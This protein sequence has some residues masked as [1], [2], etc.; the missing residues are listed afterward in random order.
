MRVQCDKQPRLQP[1]TEFLDKHMA[2]ELHTVIERDAII[3]NIV[4][5][6]SIPMTDDHWK[7]YS[8]VL[9]RCKQPLELHELLAR[10]KN[11]FDHFSGLETPNVSL[12]LREAHRVLAYGTSIGMDLEQILAELVKINRRD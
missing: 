5:K 2:D 3:H 11:E 12:S 10:G 6:V 4:Y 1:L 9:S 7:L 8:Q